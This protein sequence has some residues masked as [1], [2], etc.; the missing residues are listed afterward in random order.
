MKALESNK[1]S[2]WRLKSN[3][4]NVTDQQLSKKSYADAVRLKKTRGHKLTTAAMSFTKRF[5]GD[6]LLRWCRTL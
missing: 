5:A 3:L 6:V 1:L 4:S 2:Q